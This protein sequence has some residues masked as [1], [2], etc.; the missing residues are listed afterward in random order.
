M[1]TPQPPIRHGWTTSVQQEDIRHVFRNEFGIPYYRLELLRI[2]TLEFFDVLTTRRHADIDDEDDGSFHHEVLK[3]A[4]DLLQRFHCCAPLYPNIYVAG[5]HRNRISSFFAKDVFCSVFCDDIQAFHNLENPDVLT[6]LLD[7]T[8]AMKLLW[9]GSRLGG[10]RP[11]D[12]T[13]L[14]ALRGAT[15]AWAMAGHRGRKNKVLWEL[16]GL[17]S[18]ADFERR[19]RHTKHEFWCLEG[20]IVA[21][22]TEERGVA[23]YATLEWNEASGIK[24]GTK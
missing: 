1:A 5:K 21:A 16:M 11:Q 20:R 15:E 13:F 2:R 19:T 18:K 24:Q 8:T 6:D 17:T 23:C 22:T 14:E 7:F 3:N 9:D 4:I 12:T 10:C